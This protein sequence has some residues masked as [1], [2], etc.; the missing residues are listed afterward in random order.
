MRL[1]SSIATYWE[2][3][4]TGLETSAANLWG[5]QHLLAP[6]SHNLGG[7]FELPQGRLS[8]TV[9]LKICIFCLS[10]GCSNAGVVERLPGRQIH[11][12]LV[13]MSQRTDVVPSVREI[14]RCDTV[15]YSSEKIGSGSEYSQYFISINFPTCRSGFVFSFWEGRG[16][17]GSSS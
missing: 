3:R 10:D 5:T 16:Y 2:R 1:L 12:V 8:L 11:L 13:R 14:D 6:C 15:L 17:I 4:A 9:S 7:P